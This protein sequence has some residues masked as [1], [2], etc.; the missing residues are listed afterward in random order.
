MPVLPLTEEQERWVIERTLERNVRAFEPAYANGGFGPDTYPCWSAYVNRDVL[1]MFGTDDW[2]G[3]EDVGPRYKDYCARQYE[4][5]EEAT[6]RKAGNLLHYG[7]VLGLIAEEHDPERGRG[8][9]LVH[10][11]LRWI[12]EGTGYGKRA[13]Q[14]RGLPPAEQEA[15]D[16][17]E[18]RMRRLHATL[19]R[20]ARLKADVH[21]SDMVDAIL[22]QDPE[23]VV[24]DYWRGRGFV[25]EWLLGKSLAGSAT[26]VR[27]THHALEMDR[28]QLHEWLRWLSSLRDAAGYKF[29]SRQRE[30]AALPEHAAIPDADAD[31]LGGLL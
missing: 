19:D 4:P 3:I 14:V 27:E 21:I 6:W 18:A 10:G 13:V 7:R 24:P 26:V 12:V 2:I 20:K 11:E 29:F 28:R 16:R 9:R 8:W 23:T 31:A 22:E 30:R 17:Y 1:S 25:P 5:F 15:R